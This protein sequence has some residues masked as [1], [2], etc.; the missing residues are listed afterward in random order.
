ME[1]SKFYIQKHEEEREEEEDKETDDIIEELS[2][3]PKFVS[4]APLPNKSASNPISKSRLKRY[5]P[6][7]WKTYFTN[8]ALVD[9]VRLKK[10]N[11]YFSTIS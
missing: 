2:K 8:T 9:D 11:T 6:I 3:I 7:D 4:K 1:K 5:E 10:I